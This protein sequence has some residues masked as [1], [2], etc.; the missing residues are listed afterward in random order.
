MKVYGRVIH[1]RKTKNYVFLT[2]LSKDKEQIQIVVDKTKFENIEEND[3]ISVD[4]IKD[5]YNNIGD[6]LI[7]NSIKRIALNNKSNFNELNENALMVKSKITHK[8]RN[9]LDDKEFIEV[10][11]PILSFSESS[12]ASHSFSAKHEISDDTV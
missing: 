10:D 6:S 8:V 9:F 5:N 11:L 1:I 2:L 7:A 12:S 4:G 3:I